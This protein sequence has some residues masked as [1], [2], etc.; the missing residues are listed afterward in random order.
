MCNFVKDIGIWNYTESILPHPSYM[1]KQKHR[2]N[3]TPYP[4]KNGDNIRIKLEKGCSKS[5]LIS[6]LTGS[7]LEYGE[8]FDIRKSDIEKIFY[9]SDNGEEHVI[10]QLTKL[11]MESTTIFVKIKD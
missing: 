8:N 11:S 9:K 7:G 10:R 6:H 5:T 3:C 2:Y 4:Y 1:G